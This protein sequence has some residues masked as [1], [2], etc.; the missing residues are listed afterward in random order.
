MTEIVFIYNAK[1]GPINSLIDWAHKII[2]PNTYECSLCSITYDNLGKK[3]EWSAFL[4][5]LKIKASFLYKDHIVNDIDLKDSSL[6][7]AYLR[8]NN[9]IKL[10]ISSVEMNSFK[11]LNELILCLRK[12]LEEYL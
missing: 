6:P 11:D 3:N 10:I 12:K 9:N 1:S 8:V 4:K 2:S 5:E 7:C